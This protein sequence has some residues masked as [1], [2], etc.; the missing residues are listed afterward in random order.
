MLLII[1]F[2]LCFNLFSECV[3]RDGVKLRSR[4]SKKAPVTWQVRKYFPFKS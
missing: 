2:F 1:S 3:V 4:P